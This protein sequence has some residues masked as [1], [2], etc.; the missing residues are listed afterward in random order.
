MNSLRAI[1]DATVAG[2]LARLRA[3]FGNDAAFPN[4]RD[5]CGDTCLSYAIL[6]GPLELVRTLLTLGADPNYDDP[7]GVPALLSAVDRE[8]P[9][10]YEVLELLLAAGADITRRGLNDYTALHYAACHDDVAAVELLLRHG[11]DPAAATRIDDYA[12]AAEQAERLGH[13][14]GAAAVRRWQEAHPWPS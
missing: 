14:A 9:D 1:H 6:F 10:R 2:D 5:E 3:A 8:A 4:V 12:T 11:A 7:G 13:H